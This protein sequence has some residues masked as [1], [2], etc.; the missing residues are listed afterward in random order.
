VNT[1][2][3][4]E[5]FEQKVWDYVR[6]GWAV[7]EQTGVRARLNKGKDTVQLSLRADGQIDIDGPALP[8]VVMDGRLR[9]W[10]VLIVM[11]V[12]GYGLAWLLGFFG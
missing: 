1:Q 9:A 2:I 8:A 6:G 7:V 12:V 3:D 10:L 11:L 4:R 5:R